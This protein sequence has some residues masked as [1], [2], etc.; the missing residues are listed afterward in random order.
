MTS[1]CR[2]AVQPYLNS[3][4]VHVWKADGIVEIRF[5]QETR[6]MVCEQCRFSCILATVNS[7]V[8]VNFRFTA[9]YYPRWGYF[10]EAINGLYGNWKDNR[11]FWQIS[12]AHGPLQFGET[13]L[14]LLLLFAKNLLQWI[15]IS[16]VF[17]CHEYQWGDKNEW[18]DRVAI[19]EY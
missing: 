11:T 4:N 3:K 10:I 7:F 13:C 17:I 6:I 19:I 16:F 14:V 12:N 5:R 8:H 15:N 2:C 1:L 18:L 9:T